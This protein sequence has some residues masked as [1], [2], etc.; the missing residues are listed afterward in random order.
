MVGSSQR[1]KTMKPEAEQKIARVIANETPQEL[2]KMLL[3]AEIVGSMQK[4]PESRVAVAE[5]A[6]M[7]EAKLDR[8]NM[9][10]FG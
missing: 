9:R 10:D 1:S 2:Q 8:A 6:R 5:A 7:I 4:T 3:I